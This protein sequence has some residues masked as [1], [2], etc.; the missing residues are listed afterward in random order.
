MRKDTQIFS[1]AATHPQ[2]DK[3]ILKIHNIISALVFNTNSMSLDNGKWLTTLTN[4]NKT[5]VKA[6]WEKNPQTFQNTTNLF[7]SQIQIAQQSPLQ[8][9]NQNALA[10]PKML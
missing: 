2:R 9:H 8:L 6:R 4:G 5:M 10:S 3:I 1:G 7:T